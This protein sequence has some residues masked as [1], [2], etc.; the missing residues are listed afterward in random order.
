MPDQNSPTWRLHKCRSNCKLKYHRSN[1]S[2]W[3]L[4][5]PKSLHR[6]FVLPALHLLPHD[7]EFRGNA[8]LHHQLTSDRNADSKFKLT[9]WT[10]RQSFNLKSRIDRLFCFAAS[11]LSLARDSRRAGRHWVHIIPFLAAAARLPRRHLRRNSPA[12]RQNPGSQT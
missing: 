3:L 8:I 7:L 1:D 9:S 12:P 10:P 11:L 6:L 4:F 5:I 2:S